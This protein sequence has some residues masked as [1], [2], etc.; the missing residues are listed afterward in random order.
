ML[1]PVRRSPGKKLDEESTKRSSFAISS[2]NKT[3]SVAVGLRILIQMSQCESNIVVK[4]AALLR[5]NHP[6]TTPR[7]LFPGSPSESCFLKSCHLCHNE[8]CP[9][10]DIYMYR[11]DQ[12]FCSVEC[13]SRQMDLD[14]RK[15]IE[16]S[17]KR[18]LKSFR[19][20]CET[21]VLQ[22]NFR[23]CHKP[24]PPQKYRAIFL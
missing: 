10:Q 22:D 4:S 1:L 3:N 9:D 17:T 7:K 20:R 8:L 16:A 6:P 19:H 15:E 11:G 24:L 14:E 12:G 23:R 18:M 5:L 2:N 21:R 13:R